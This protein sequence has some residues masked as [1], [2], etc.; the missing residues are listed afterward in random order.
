MSRDTHCDGA[1]STG[2]VCILL[3]NHSGDHKP[4]PT[5]EQILD[6]EATPFR[7]RGTKLD[8]I[9][10]DLGI[11]LTRYYQL[12]NRYIHTEAAAAYDPITTRRA[13]QHTDR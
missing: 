2:H 9:R 11:N 10:R 7:D 3:A 6:F 12:L 5:L 4:T 13:L 8:R 1:T